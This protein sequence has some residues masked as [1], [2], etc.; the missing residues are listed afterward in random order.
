MQFHDRFY[1]NISN[2]FASDKIT[3]IDQF[4]RFKDFSELI[5]WSSVFI[6]VVILSLPGVL[7]NNINARRFI[8]NNY[9]LFFLMAFFGIFIDTFAANLG[10]Y[11]HSANDSLAFFTRVFMILIEE[12]GE[13]GII[14]VAC[15]WL[16]GLNF[17][18]QSK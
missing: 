1:E 16:F 6:I 8:F 14:A 2:I 12:L 18:Y 5:Y 10:K 15:I 4:L 11:F 7:K 9:K 3:F 13:I 17:R